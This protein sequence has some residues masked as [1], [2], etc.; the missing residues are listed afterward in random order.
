MNFAPSKPL[1]SAF[2]VLLGPESKLNCLDIRLQSSLD[3]FRLTG[4]E[5]LS[6]LLDGRQHVVN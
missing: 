1:D 4:A 5:L 3:R 2:S 6:Q